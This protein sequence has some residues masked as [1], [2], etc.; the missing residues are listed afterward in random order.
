MALNCYLNCYKRDDDC[1]S[2][3]WK[4]LHMF[5]EWVAWQLWFGHA[6]LVTF[7]SAIGQV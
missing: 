4:R 3:N 7:K 1:V 6:I 2:S 5:L